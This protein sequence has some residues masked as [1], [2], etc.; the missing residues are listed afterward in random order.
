MVRGNCIGLSANPAPVTVTE[1]TTR[2]AL[3]VLLTMTVLELVVPTLTLPN[4]RLVGLVD[5]VGDPVVPP[6]P[7]APAVPQPDTHRRMAAAAATRQIVV[8]A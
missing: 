2:S 5:T 6:P 3:P 1:E 4:E 7:D 8:I